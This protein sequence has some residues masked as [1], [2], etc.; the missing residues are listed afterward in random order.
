LPNG[1]IFEHPVTIPNV[2]VGAN[3]TEVL[4][5]IHQAGYMIPT[6]LTG[7]A[8]MITTGDVDEFDATSSGGL[9]ISMSVVTLRLVL[10]QTQ[11]LIGIVPS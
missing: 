6:D 4:E 10:E 8:M 9:K 11:Y 5:A 2:S 7:E 1:Q 3:Y